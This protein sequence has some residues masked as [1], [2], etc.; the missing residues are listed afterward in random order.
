ML[1]LCATFAVLAAPGAS[2]LSGVSYDLTLVLR[3][4]LGREAPVT[5]A[6]AVV[7][8]IDE[9]TYTHPP[10]A[11]TPKAAWPQYLAEVYAAVLDAGAVVV[12]QD[13]VLP[14]S[15]DAISPGIDTPYLAML[16]RY[17][18]AEGRVVLGATLHQGAEVAPHPSQQLFVGCSLE[19][20]V[21]QRSH[22]S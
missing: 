8:G 11:G 19:C 16:A 10:F 7:I 13:V 18:R 6:P 14:T 20:Q 21:A 17:G 15:L 5:P 1:A 3:A 9:E 12:G 4:T 2:W 22:G